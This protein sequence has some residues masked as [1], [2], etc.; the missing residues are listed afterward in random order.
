MSTAVKE[1][2]T[3][4]VRSTDADGERFDLLSPP[5]MRRLA[6]VCAE[7]AEKYSAHN[8]ER[9]MPVTDLLNHGL[10]HLFLYLAGNR[11]EDHLGHALWNIAGAIHSEECSPEE[12]WRC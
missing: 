3:G 4:A 6:A 11:D 1:F 7:G 8:W 10:R 5:A 9:G 12:L 2:E